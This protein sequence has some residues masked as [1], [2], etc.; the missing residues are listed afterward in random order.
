MLSDFPHNLLG[1][2]KHGLEL[3]KPK[4]VF[5][6]KS[7]AKKVS[8]VCKGLH[9]V[10]RVI[11]IDND[12]AVGLGNS[13]ITLTNFIK[14]FENSNFNLTNHTSVKVNLEEQVAL[15]LN[16]SGTTGLPKGVM[17]TQKNMMCVML[18][19]RQLTAASKMLFDQVFISN[20]APWFH[21]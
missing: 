9:Y 7:V 12:G 18:S 15:I 3:A 2:F 4:F 20:I 14:K 1:E 5:V 8:T 11:V 16:S 21:A 6:T 17:I 19:Y 10:K 13:V